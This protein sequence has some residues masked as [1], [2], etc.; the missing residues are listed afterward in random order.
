MKR[1]GKKRDSDKCAHLLTVVLS[2][3]THILLSKSCSIAT[4]RP[5]FN[6]LPRIL[7]VSSFST[8][9]I[10]FLAGFR[11]RFISL[12]STLLLSNSN[13][14]SFWSGSRFMLDSSISL[15]KLLLTLLSLLNWLLLWL[16][17]SRWGLWFNGECIDGTLSKFSLFRRFDS[18][19]CRAWGLLG[20]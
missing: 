7:F 18:R 4:L 2:K 19:F 8:S 6:E 16:W 20:K 14:F 5:S 3:D 11:S 1:Y 9:F 12:S 13:S 17:S 10:V 15:I